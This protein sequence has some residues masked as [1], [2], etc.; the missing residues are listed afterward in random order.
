M[1]IAQR[2]WSVLA[3]LKDMASRARG[4]VSARGAGSGMRRSD[5]D[6]RRLLLAGGPTGLSVVSVLSSARLAFLSTSQ[7]ALLDSAMAVAVSALEPG[8]L[9]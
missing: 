1:M 2:D 9:W 8:M 5:G 3:G 7:A 6:P 4:S